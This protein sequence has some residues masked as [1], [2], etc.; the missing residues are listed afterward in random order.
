MN[1]KS[2]IEA[3]AIPL[4]QIH[5]FPTWYL[6]APQKSD[7]LHNH[8]TRNKKWTNKRTYQQN[9]NYRKKQILDK[10]IL[11]IEI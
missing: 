2:S 8:K 6:L 5:M 10:S 4:R 1:K 7:Y 9:L 3:E 11:R